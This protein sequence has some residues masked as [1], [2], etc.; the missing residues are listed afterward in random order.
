MYMFFDQNLILD[1]E[2]MWSSMRKI[3]SKSLGQLEFGRY[4]ISRHANVDGDVVGGCRS[5][6]LGGLNKEPKETEKS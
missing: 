4:N 6:T 5:W 3:D 1:K 2:L